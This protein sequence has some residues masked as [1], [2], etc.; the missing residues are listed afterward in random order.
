MTVI[1][2]NRGGGE[3]LH[4]DEASHLLLL[5]LLSDLVAVR[6][7]EP[8]PQ[9]AA[10]LQAITTDLGKIVERFEPPQGAA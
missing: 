9:R 8:D 2:F 5:A 4:I 10:R 3:P 6:D 1:P 7:G